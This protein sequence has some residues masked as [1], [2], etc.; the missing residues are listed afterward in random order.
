MDEGEDG[1][2]GD[3]VKRQLPYDDGSKGLPEE[4][5]AMAALMTR[6]YVEGWEVQEVREDLEEGG[7][8][9]DVAEDAPGGNGI[10]TIDTG[11]TSHGDPHAGQSRLPG[12]DL[13]DLEEVT[14]FET[15]V[16]WCW[17]V[18]LCVAL[19]AMWF[20]ICT[21]DPI[22]GLTAQGVESGAVGAPPPPSTPN[23]AAEALEA[24][25]GRNG[26]DLERG[27]PAAYFLVGD[28]CESRRASR[29]QRAGESVAR[30]RHGQRCASGGCPAGGAH[31][32]GAG[33]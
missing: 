3:G 23:P 28:L 1:G 12:E 18:V 25:V 9:E 16:A 2:D 26:F 14:P 15:G 29:P 24:S 19:G 13:E 5:N 32:P 6:L 7:D 11:G 8:E 33:S 27:L 30:Q 4:M 31:F 17:T 20:W 22:Q 21:D 10:T